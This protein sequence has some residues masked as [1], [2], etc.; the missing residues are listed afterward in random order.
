VKRILKEV[1]GRRDQIARE[2]AAIRADAATL[3]ASVA[4][5][6]RPDKPEMKGPA[7]RRSQEDDRSALLAAA[8]KTWDAWRAPGVSHRFPATLPPD[9]ERRLRARYDE[10]TDCCGQCSN[11]P[12]ARWRHG[13]PEQCYDKMTDAAAKTQ[14]WIT[15]QLMAHIKPT[16]SDA[17]RRLAKAD[18]QCHRAERLLASRRQALAAAAAA[19]DQARQDAKQD[20]QNDLREL[21]IAREVLAVHSRHNEHYVRELARRTDTASPVECGYLA[22][23]ALRAVYDLNRMH[24]RA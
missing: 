10:A 17:G 15:A 9:F 23:A 16:V 20:K 3:A 2:V 4:A 6:E 19:Y 8:K 14:G 22:V 7:V 18:T 13:R 21:E 24:G 12:P 1:R 5:V 11:V